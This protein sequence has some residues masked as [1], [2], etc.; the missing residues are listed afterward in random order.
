MET[1]SHGVC[2]SVIQDTVGQSAH[3]DKPFVKML[4][5]NKETKYTDLL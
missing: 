2:V 1:Q 5:L 4:Y 3:T